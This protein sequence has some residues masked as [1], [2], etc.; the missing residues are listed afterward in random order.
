M[1]CVTVSNVNENVTEN[2]GTKAKDWFDFMAKRVGLAQH[3]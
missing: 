2:H 3:N 1:S